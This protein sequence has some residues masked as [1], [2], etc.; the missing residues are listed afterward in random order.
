[1]WFLDVSYY[2][3]FYFAMCSFYVLMFFVLTFETLCF[4][5]KGVIIHV[6]LYSHDVT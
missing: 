2:V 4:L 1:M 6:G 5:L 3:C